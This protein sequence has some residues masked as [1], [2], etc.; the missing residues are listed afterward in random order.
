MHSKDRYPLLMGCVK[1]LNNICG[2]NIE[3]CIHESGKKQYLYKLPNYIKHHFDKYDG[4]MHRA[5][6]LN[7]GVRKLSTK[8]RLVLMDS[9][10]IINKEWWD[11]IKYIDKPCIAWGEMIYLSKYSTKNFIENNGKE[12]KIE[13][14]KQP[15]MM[16]AA[17][18]II[19]CPKDVFYRVK[20]IPEDFKDTWGGPDNSF[21]IKLDT[22]GYK[23]FNIDST[24]FH[25]WH[26]KNTPRITNKQLFVWDMMTWTR[27]TWDLVLENIGDD[28][29]R[30]N[31][32]YPDNSKYKTN[33]KW[34]QDK[35]TK[36]LRKKKR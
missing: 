35:K 3:I 11:N 7:R 26:E 36:A 20:G 13:K 10:I 6:S 18:G 32:K 14:I 28:W 23:F 27:K 24:V 9:D 29:G 31:A 12:I 15:T 4:I 33:K 5:W 2:D 16:G 30:S 21:L 1:S 8:N 34:T 19:Y 17:G 25:L 22:Y